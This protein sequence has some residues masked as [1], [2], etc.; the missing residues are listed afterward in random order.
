MI[1][2]AVPLN[3][4]LANPWQPRESED[5]EHVKSLALSIQRDGLLQ[6]PVGRVVTR[7]G[8]PLE[9]GSEP[10]YGRDERVQL[11]FGHSRLAAYYWLYQNDSGYELAWAKLPVVVRYISDEEMFRLAISENL[12]RRDLTAIEEAKAM[13]RYRDDFGKSSVEIGELFGLSDSAVRNKMRL[14]KLPE[15]IQERLR[16]RLLSEGAARALLAIYEIPEAKRAAAE[17]IYG[18][19][20]PS[21]IIEMALSGTAPA[22]ISAAIDALAER[23]DPQPMQLGIEAAPV[24]VDEEIVDAGEEDA[25]EEDAEAVKAMQEAAEVFQSESVSVETAVEEEEETGE[26]A[27]EK[28]PAS[29]AQ[30]AV[31]ARQSPTPA[32]TP[33][34]AQPALEETPKPETKP[35]TWKESTISLTITL[36]PEDGNPEGRMAAMGAR[37]NLETPRMVMARQ[38][39]L[40]LPGQLEAM[41]LELYQEYQKRSEA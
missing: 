9:I 29:P 17:L 4:V 15:F 31:P 22:Q 13:T 18:K 12:Q 6:K 41:M 37:V 30:P 32:A 24:P 19:Q 39:S 26:I 27:E 14:L 7:F 1:E 35:L 5:A 2:L 40:I 36:W 34:P 23:I 21:E 20:K 8:R 16:G 28:Q 33:R 38:A 11:A 25:A 3:C 10:D